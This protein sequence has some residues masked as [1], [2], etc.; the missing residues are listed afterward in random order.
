MF[1]QVHNHSLGSLSVMYDRSMD[2]FMLPRGL[3]DMPNIE[4]MR[5]VLYGFIHIDQYN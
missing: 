2:S 1:L 5:A 4:S 3:G